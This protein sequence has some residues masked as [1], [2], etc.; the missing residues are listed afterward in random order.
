MEPEDSLQ[1]W[2]RAGIAATA[3]IILSVPLYL[4]K[5]AFKPPRAAAPPVPLY[6]GSAA[7]RQCH[8]K[9]YDAWKGSHHA[10]A[11]LAPLPDTVLGDFN[12]AVFNDGKKT[13]RFYKKHAKY[14]VRTDD[15]AGSPKDFEIAYAFGW[16]PLQQYLVLFP[17]GRLQCL[18]VAWDIEKKHFLYRK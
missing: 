17:G 3:A 11:M 5:Q 6:V 18:S 10:L 15:L 7:C 16:F 12:N 13:W 8:A 4:G 1:R 2:K 14:F 9:E